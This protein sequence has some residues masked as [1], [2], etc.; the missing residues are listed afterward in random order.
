MKRILEDIKTGNFRP[1][2]LLY[3]T[4]D[5][6]KFQYRDK[7]LKALVPEG[8]TMNFTAFEGKDIRREEII[9]LGQTRPIFAERRVILIENS[10]WFATKARGENED[11]PQKSA[12]KS[13]FEEE[14][15]E[16]PK[17][18]ILIFVESEI[19]RKL[20]IY[21]VVK[22]LGIDVEFAVQKEEDILRWMYQ[23]IRK[24]GKDTDAATVRYLLQ[25]TGTD[26]SSISR[27][28]EKLLCYTLN[29]QMVSIEDIDAIVSTDIQDKVFE[30]VDA[31]TS[32]NQKKALELYYNLL[33]LKEPPMKILS[34]IARQFRILYEIK[35]MTR[36]GGLANREIAKA[37]GVPEFTIRKYQAMCRNYSQ[38]LL[39]N[40]LEEIVQA[41]EDVKMGRLADK[42]SVELFL[43]KYSQ[44][45]KKEE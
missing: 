39:R 15:K 26:M 33:T 38:G 35:S 24:E 19:N 43:V 36:R 9:E 31:L 45:L 37:A 4:E 28:M 44:P 8:D 1:C 17:T 16:L 42:I 21:N 10:G 27:E 2:Y 29:Q 25:K 30:M 12:S 40:A 13:T 18:T 14:L 3:G 22:T 6:V 5:Y 7:L 32:Y 41:E 34:L 23:K 20:K 11:K